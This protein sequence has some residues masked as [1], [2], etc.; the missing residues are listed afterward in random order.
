MAKNNRAASLE[1]YIPHDIIQLTKEKVVSIVK[2][3]E[4]N[5][6]HEKYNTLMS[7]VDMF[8]DSVKEE[9]K[10]R[11]KS[12]FDN[13]G[14]KSIQTDIGKI[15]LINRTDYKLNDEQSEK[16]INYMKAN[17]IPIE[18]VFD[19]EYKIVTK[20]Q[21]IINQLL[22]KGYVTKTHK[23]NKDLLKIALEKNPEIKSFIDIKEIEYIK[24]L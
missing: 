14:E 12:I 16:L 3:T 5:L 23:L 13:T 1:K 2:Q 17:S 19:V 8:V 6:L 15:L 18:T 24:G 22:D 4:T 20:N 7:F 21:K 11:L 10:S 9:I